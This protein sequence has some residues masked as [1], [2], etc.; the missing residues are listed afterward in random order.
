M[1]YR[2]FVRGL[3]YHVYTLGEVRELARLYKKINGPIPTIIQK[4]SNNRWTVMPDR[5]QVR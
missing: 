4:F 3:T 1:K 5:F 2:L